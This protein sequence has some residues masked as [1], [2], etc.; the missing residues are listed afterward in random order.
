MEIIMLYRS[1]RG[2]VYYTPENTMPAFL[3]ALEAGYDYIETDPQLTLDG[4][5]V[6]MHDGTIN[7]T[8]RNSDGSKIE[9]P[10]EVSKTTYAELMQYDAGIAMGEKFR[11]TKIPRLDELL[12]AAEG[13]DVIIALDKKIPTDK[14][15]ALLDV[16]EKHD[17]KV[18]FS[19][20]DTVRIQKI[21]ERFPDARFDYDVN[22]ED[23]ALAQV[24]NLVKPKNLIVWMY[25]DKPNFSWLAQKAKVSPE[26]YARVKKYARVGIANVNTPIDV[27]E[28]LEYAPDILEI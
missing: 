12:A 15:D 18:C 14:I 22:L 13:H 7:R 17:T 21:Q 6:L 24:C 23:E 3:Y 1:H 19:A 10:V 26:N 20:S 9:K 2:G 5:V 28:A 25:L 27:K 8:C 4:V 16:V 11:G